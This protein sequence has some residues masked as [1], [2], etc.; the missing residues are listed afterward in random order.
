MTYLHPDVVFFVILLEQTFF[1]LGH[2]VYF[3]YT[4]NYCLHNIK[5]NPCE[6]DQFSLF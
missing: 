5:F 1:S 4:E 6:V 2:K 3:K